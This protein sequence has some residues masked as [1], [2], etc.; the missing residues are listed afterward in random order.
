MSMN[1]L[2]VGR[3]VRQALKEDVGTG[4]ITTALTVPDSSNSR[5]M[6]VVKGRGVIAGLDVAAL[7]FR[8]VEGVK[9][10]AKTA[11]K[12][13]VF[14]PSVEDG[15]RVE[16]GDIVAEIIG[17]TG[18]ILIGERVALNFLQRMS[19]IA[20][21][22]AG[23]VE[24]V[25]HTDARII[26]T[27]K[28]T[29]GLRILEKYAVQA[30]GGHNHRFGLYDA[31]LIKDNHIEAAGG[32]GEAVRRAKSAPHTVKIEV[33][34]EN[35]EQVNEALDAGADMILLD[36]MSHDQLVEAVGLCRGRAITE[37]SGGITEES[38]AAIAETGVDLI[39]VGALTHSVES[40][41]LSL[42]ITGSL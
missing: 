37:A 12:S 4:D 42:E 28:T 5:A 17:P 13:V 1:Y 26:D 33:E 18:L 29:P 30:G 20:T 40:L 16:P 22:T 25:K 36:N 38:I 15:A 39:S 6:I 9:P 14:S 11:G 3:I 7:V 19:G 31:V 23:F 34:V 8:E 24:L 2:K 32:V 10:A 27:R 35:I 21:K 41:D